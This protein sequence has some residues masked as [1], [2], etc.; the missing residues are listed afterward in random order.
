MRGGRGAEPFPR[1]AR[2]P[3]ARPLGVRPSWWAPRGA[4]TTTCS[5]GEP[6]I[7]G[8]GGSGLRAGG[9][10]DQ[11][12]ARRILAS[13][14]P[15]ANVRQLQPLAGAL[16]VVPPLSLAGRAEPA[17]GGTVVAPG[18]ARVTV[19]PVTLLAGS[20][21]DPSATVAE[22]PSGQAWTTANV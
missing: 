16:P 5:S 10:P 11:S 6:I 14:A 20:E 22:G 15:A 4:S 21:E 13:P 17:V 9:S 18:A 8:R 1:W 19:V 7:E 12:M 3:G 2:P